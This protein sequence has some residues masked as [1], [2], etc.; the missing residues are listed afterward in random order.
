MF[1]KKKISKSF[2]LF[3]E[4]GGEPA[5]AR[6]HGVPTPGKPFPWDQH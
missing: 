4:S 5:G 1:K 6:I 2:S 3:R